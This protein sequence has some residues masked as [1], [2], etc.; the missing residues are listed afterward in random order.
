MD[1]WVCT[2]NG[3]SINHFLLVKVKIFI[4]VLQSINIIANGHRNVYPKVAGCHQCS[5]CRRQVHHATVFLVPCFRGVNICCTSSLHSSPQPVPMVDMGKPVFQAP[6]VRRRQGN[7]I[8]ACKS[9]PEAGKQC[10]AQN[11][12]FQPPSN[13]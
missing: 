3:R 8:G 11:A 1:P 7:P 6:F 9:M 12:F 13:M 4:P 5:A 2:P 10:A